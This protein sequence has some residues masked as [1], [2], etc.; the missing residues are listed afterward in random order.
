MQTK[1]TPYVLGDQAKKTAPVLELANAKVLNIQLRRGETIPEHKAD[2]EVVI[3]VRGGQVEFTAEGE[4][5]LATPEAV[6]HLPPGEKHQLFAK[7]DSD[8]L[9]FQIKA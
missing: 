1:A 6:L 9:V 8:L 3:V 4:T 7:E 5:A 2:A